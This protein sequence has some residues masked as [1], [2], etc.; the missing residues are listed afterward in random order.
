MPIH[1]WINYGLRWK[2]TTLTALFPTHHTLAQGSLRYRLATLGYQ[3]YNTYGVETFTLNHYSWHDLL[4][5]Q[6]RCITIESL[7]QTYGFVINMQR[8]RSCANILMII[9][10]IINVSNPQH[11]VYYYDNS[12]NVFDIVNVITTQRRGYGV[13]IPM[14]VFGNI[15]APIAQLGTSCSFDSPGL[16][17]NEP[18]PGKHPQGDSTP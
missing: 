2:G 4:R 5:H 17:R 12:M 7:A 14:N 1:S 16:A 18:T 15:N 8:R 10:V 3:K 6:W 9:F 11:H 13:G